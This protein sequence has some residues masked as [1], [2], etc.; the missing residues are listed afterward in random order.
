MQRIKLAALLP[1][2]AVGTLYAQAVAP[3]PS[4]QIP[5]DPLL[6]F[7]NPR[8]DALGQDLQKAAGDVSNSQVF[9]TQ[10]ANLDAIAK[11]ATDRIFSSGRRAAL[12][13]IEASKTWQRLWSRVETARQ[14][15]ELTSQQKDEWK[16]QA[17]ALA[18]QIQALTTTAAQAD[19]SLKDAGDLLEEIG[20]AREIAAIGTFLQKRNLADIT[21]TDLRIVAK[22]QQAIADTGAV[23]SRLAAEHPPATSRT[24]ADQMKVDLAKAEL[25][26]LKIL[27]GIEEKR[28]A[29]QQDVSDLLAVIGETLN[30]SSAPTCIFSFVDN[31][32]N[33]LPAL[34]I[35]STEAIEDTLQRFPSDK[36]RLSTVVYLL[37]NY[38]ALTARADIPLRLAELRSAIEDRRFAIRQ[39][40]IMARTYEQILLL[41]AQRIA[42]YSKGGVKPETLAQ[43]ANALS[44]AGLIPTI[45]VK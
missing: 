32:A 15:A 35:P 18:K 43:F 31:E 34:E 19:T 45:A 8:L 12:A 30:C 40:A 36:V 24:V 29:G 25:D 16:N 4:P 14:S 5:R 38:A 9:E 41:G 7:Y 44:T 13:K 21:P 28:L 27:I 37:E 42:A 22:L 6:Y 10:L 39:Q 11:L 33:T 20:K 23:I 26:H 3:A 17:D 2:F 1:L